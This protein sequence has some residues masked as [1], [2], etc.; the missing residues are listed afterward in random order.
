MMLA[1][2][3]VCLAAVTPFKAAT[4]GLSVSGMPRER[5]EFYTEY[6]AQQMAAAGLAV[7]SPKQV[8]SLLGL[9][10]QRQL[11]GCSQESTSCTAEMAAAL[12]VDG[13]VQGE[14]VKLES[15]G[16]QVSLKVLWSRDGRPLT[17]F[18]GRGE[19]EPALLDLMGRGARLMSDDLTQGDWVRL[20]VTPAS[21]TII[22]SSPLRVAAWVSFGVGVAALAGGTVGIVRSTTLAEQL[23]T[24]SFVS[25][26]EARAVASDGN[27]MQVMGGVLLGVGA[28]ALGAGVV[29]FL[30]GTSGAPAA[31]PT[32][33]F[34]P[35]GLSLGFVGVW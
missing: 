17:V 13:I 5:A 20:T 28:A 6:V 10:R 7:T 8:A 32:V 12:G 24:G 2:S 1:M 18:T 19:D 3:L 14:V 35:G 15:G 16:F 31:A 27:T 4:T 11:L 22:P 23:R 26:G 34:S 33:M 25:L 30:L 29:M 9:E 21:H